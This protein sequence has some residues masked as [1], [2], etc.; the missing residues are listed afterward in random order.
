MEHAHEILTRICFPVDPESTKQPLQRASEIRPVSELLSIIRLRGADV[1]F[2]SIA[3]G[4][5]EH[6]TGVALRALLGNIIAFSDGQLG[7]NT[8]VAASK[9]SSRPSSAPKIA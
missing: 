7:S 1:P 4:T 8:E 3:S 5:T 2:S 6:R 9:A